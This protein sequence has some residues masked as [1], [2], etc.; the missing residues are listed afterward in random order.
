ME[1]SDFMAQ[2]RAL[3][4][5]VSA[6]QDLL[7]KTIVRGIAA[8]GACIVTMT[9]KYDLR[10][11]KISDDAMAGGAA[12]LSEIVAAAFRDAKAKADAAIDKIMGDATAGMPLP[13]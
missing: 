13:E 11:L 8:G 10:D 12:A 1:M 5:K 9:G 7:D 3:Q 2:A 6:A 4:D